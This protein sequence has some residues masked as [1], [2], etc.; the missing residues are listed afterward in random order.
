VSR[1]AVRRLFIAVLVALP[2]QYAFVGVIGMGA[3]EPWPALV[4]PGFQRVYET[5]DQVTVRE[6]AFEAVY[7]DGRRADVPRAVLLGD[8]PRSHWGAFLGRQCRP[9]G[10]SGAPD[11]ER[12]THPDAGA[13]FADRLSRAN[14]DPPRLDVFWRDVT[15][16]AG[17]DGA[18]RIAPLD[19]LT[20]LLPSP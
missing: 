3:S 15:R 14:L 5:A 7:A 10:L 11:S 16:P 4:M 6:T 2:I 8:L 19:T 9:Q 1:T 20:I 18:A 12:C 13:W 17:G